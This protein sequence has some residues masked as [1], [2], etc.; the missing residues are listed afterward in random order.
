MPL[1]KVREED[2]SW[3]PNT[4]PFLTYSLEPADVMTCESVGYA[5]RWVASQLQDLDSR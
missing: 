4:T 1:V 2:A 5:L 3:R